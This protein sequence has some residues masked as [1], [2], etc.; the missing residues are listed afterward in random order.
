MSASLLG[1]VTVSELVSSKQMLVEVDASESLGSVLQL[2]DKH[3]LLSVRAL[4]RYLPVARLSQLLT[5]PALYCRFRSMGNPDPG[6]ERAA[7]NSSS[8]PSSTLESSPSSTS[9]R[10]RSAGSLLA[11]CPAS[12]LPSI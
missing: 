9:S 3:Q 6:S 7:P 2:L 8:A 5:W 4:P 10:L 1:C 12:L 11:L